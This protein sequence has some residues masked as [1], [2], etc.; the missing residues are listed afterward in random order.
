VFIFWLL[1][2]IG[3]LV[4]DLIPIFITPFEKSVA[5]RY[6]LTPHFTCNILVQFIHLFQI[7]FISVTVARYFGCARGIYLIFAHFCLKLPAKNISLY[8]LLNLLPAFAI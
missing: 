6:M 3:N 1:G 7:L 8:N 2:M 4:C 5:H